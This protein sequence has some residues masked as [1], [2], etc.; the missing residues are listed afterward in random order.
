[1]SENILRQILDEL[2]STNNGLSTI[3]TRLDRLES[4]VN[5]IKAEVSSIKSD[6]SD[7]PLIRQA[8]LETLEEVRD[9][10]ESSKKTASALKGLSY[11]SHRHLHLSSMQLIFS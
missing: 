9:V 6:T 1:M 4:E 8:V 3:N 7:I 2:K 10:K 11:P 5:S